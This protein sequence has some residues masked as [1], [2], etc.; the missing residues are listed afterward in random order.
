MIAEQLKVGDVV[1]RSGK[2]GVVIKRTPRTITIKFP[3]SECKI[4]F[5]KGF[6]ISELGITLKTE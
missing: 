5:T 3:F 6:I 4:S 2:E 1:L